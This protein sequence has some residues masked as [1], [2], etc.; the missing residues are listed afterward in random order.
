MESLKE[1]NA[2]CIVGGRYQLKSLLGTG[3]FGSVY[4]AFDVKTQREIS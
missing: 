1:P 2:E 4:L 3:A